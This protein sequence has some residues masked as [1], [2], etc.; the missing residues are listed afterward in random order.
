MA[1]AEMLLE[2]LIYYAL[3]GF[4]V[5]IVFLIF[6]IGKVERAAKGAYFFRP[7]LIPGIMLLWPVVIYRWRKL[8]QSPEQEG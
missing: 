1:V 7:Q 3:L 6:G 8:A 5:A 2:I 4:M